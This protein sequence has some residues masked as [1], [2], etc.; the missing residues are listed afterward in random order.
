MDIQKL[1]DELFEHGCILQSRED[2]A[3]SI[4]AKHLESQGS[5]E[6]PL[7]PPKGFALA[8]PDG[9]GLASLDVAQ[10]PDASI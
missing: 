8:N 10:E 3:K 4:I 5:M 9:T 7:N 6:L 2:L 1:M